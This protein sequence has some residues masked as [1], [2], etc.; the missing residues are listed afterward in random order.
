MLTKPLASELHSVKTKKIT[1]QPKDIQESVV[2][3]IVH[4]RVPLVLS[5]SGL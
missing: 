5:K 1:N 4:K 2:G 3:P